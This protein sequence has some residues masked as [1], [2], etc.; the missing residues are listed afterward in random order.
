MKVS[1]SPQLAW[2]GFTP[3]L[4]Q[5]AQVRL[6]VSDRGIARLELAR[7]DAAAVGEAGPINGAAPAAEPL[8][9]VKAKG[10]PEARTAVPAM[11][12]R[13]ESQRGEL[14]NLP[15][16]QSQ[17]LR[18]AT[19]ELESYFAGDLRC[20][21]VPIDF[22]DQGSSFQR[23]VWRALLDIPYGE[24]TTYGE[25][26]AALGKPGAARAV[27]GAVGANPIPV[28]VPCHRVVG[29]DRSLTGFSCGLSFKETLLQLE[30]VRLSALPSRSR[31]T[32]GDEALRRRRKCL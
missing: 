23:R 22:D 4:F 19:N 15:P 29:A 27:G 2:S 16:S 10:G 24:L 11:A 26:A 21:K 7:V 28:I 6:A 31:E 18:D 25:I 20:F 3:D 17:L 5:G 14:G 8:V 9:V 30:G 12:T 32:V 1:E 13:F